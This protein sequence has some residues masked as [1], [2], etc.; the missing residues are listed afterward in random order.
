MGSEDATPQFVIADTQ[1]APLSDNSVDFILVQAIAPY[2]TVASFALI[3]QQAQRILK[4]D[5]GILVVG[6]QQY[7]IS[8][9]ANGEW[10]YFVKS[11]LQ[12]EEQ[13]VQVS[14]RSLLAKT[15]DQ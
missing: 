7:D 11:R 4:P 14:Y 15:A 3:L 12:G 8:D 13:L 9:F 5:T 2:L 1:T 6:P 10:R